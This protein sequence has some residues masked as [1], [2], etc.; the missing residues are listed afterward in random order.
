MKKALTA[1]SNYNKNNKSVASTTLISSLQTIK[2]A[3]IIES[4]P[5]RNILVTRA[6]K[7]DADVTKV[8]VKLAKENY[9]SRLQAD[10]TNKHY[11]FEQDAVSSSQ[12]THHPVKS[13]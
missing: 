7:L 2:S 12:P 6:N 9:L 13:V 11:G 8:A 3:T 1:F 5:K 10:L 4:K